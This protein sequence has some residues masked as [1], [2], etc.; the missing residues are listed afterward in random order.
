M[1][2]LPNGFVGSSEGYFSVVRTLLLGV[3]WQ[4]FDVRD[5][6]FANEADVAAQLAGELGPDGA[7][8]A[9]ADLIERGILRSFRLMTLSDAQDSY[10]TEV[11]TVGGSIVTPASAYLTAPAQGPTLERVW[12]ADRQMTKVQIRGEGIDT[13]VQVEVTFDV[14]PSL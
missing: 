1:P 11:G 13:S 6:T 9:P 3:D 5:A 12:R 8:L 2:R 7:A 10:L 4:D 14:P